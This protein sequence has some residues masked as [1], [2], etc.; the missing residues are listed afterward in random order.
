[1]LLCSFPSGS[2]QITNV[3][4]HQSGLGWNSSFGLLVPLPGAIR[5]LYV[6]GRNRHGTLL[7]PMCHC[8]RLY[9]HCSVTGILGSHSQSAQRLIKLLCLFFYYHFLFFWTFYC[10]LFS[11]SLILLITKMLELA[12]CRIL[13]L[14]TMW[15]QM[16]PRSVF[17][18]LS[19][20][21]HSEKKTKK[22]T[23]NTFKEPP[24]Q[25]N[26]TLLFVI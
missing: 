13:Y 8:I 2:C 16:W 4:V 9:S 11:F 23:I 3:L 21:L 10:T 24:T 5:H 1:M 22:I 17:R 14:L 6:P 18:L 15:R 25:I 26:Y 19:E 7:W 12:P 20:A